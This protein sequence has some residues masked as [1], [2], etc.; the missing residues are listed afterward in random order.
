MPERQMPDPRPLR[1]YVS[2]KGGYRLAMHG[3]LRDHLVMMAV[4]EFP[5]DASAAVVE[6]VLKARMRVRIRRE[7]KSAIA[8]FMISVLVNIIVKLIV[9]WWFQKRSH[10]VLMEGWNHAVAAAR[11]SH[12]EAA[13]GSAP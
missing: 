8:I 11:V 6:E 9:E 4:E 12:N 7:Y 10:R 2:R 1:D 3:G 5:V 13:G